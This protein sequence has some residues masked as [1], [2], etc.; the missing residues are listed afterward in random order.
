MELY[1][2]IFLIII[3]IFVGCVIFYVRSNDN[4]MNL[5]NISFQRFIKF[6]FHKNIISSRIK[7]NMST[8]ESFTMKESVIIAESE[9]INN[10]VELNNIKYTNPPISDFILTSL[11][12]SPRLNPQQNKNNYQMNNPAI[13]NP[14]LEDP[15]N[16]PSKNQIKDGVPKIFF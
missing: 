15:S 13:D 8:Q 1:M 16:N 4:H 11:L 2:V 12:T 14:I 6:M 10:A 3:S 9:L 7:N 5:I